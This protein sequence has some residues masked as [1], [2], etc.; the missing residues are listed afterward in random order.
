MS[1]KSELITTEARFFELE[2]EWNGLLLGNA[3]HEIFLTWQWQS[4]WWRAYQPGDL[5]VVTARDEAGALVGI[6]PW[7]REAESHVIRPI[8]CVEVTDYLDILVRPD[9][10]DA[11]CESVAGILVEQRETFS[12]VN[13]CNCPGESPTL[14]SLPRAFA[15]RGF[16]TDIVQQEVCP[17][18]ALPPDFETYLNQLDKKQRHELR[19]K[20]RRAEGADQTVSWYT[21]GPGHDLAVEIEHFIDLM[22]ASAT[23]KSDFLM[24]AKNLEFFR[25]ITHRVAQCGWL[26][27][28]FLTVDGERAAAYLNFDFDNRIMVYNSGL[29]PGRYGQYSPGIVLLLYLIR[30][31]IE[32]RRTHFDFLRGDEE[33]KLRMGAKGKPVMEIKARLPQVASAA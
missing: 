18:I 22:A 24:D 33:Y 27:L 28:A 2:P 29:E 31:A 15:A 3:T 32:K 7:F 25:A 6:A 4:T 14:E 17:V 13:L 30:D 21:V 23:D 11:F 26:Q 12:R 8:G 16:E 20:L 5:F 1:L 19:R 9:Q 10:R